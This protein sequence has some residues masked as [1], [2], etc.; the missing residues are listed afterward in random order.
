MEDEELP[1]SWMSTHAIKTD[2]RELLMRLHPEK[3]WPKRVSV[4]DLCEYTVH[5]IPADSQDKDSLR[6]L[7]MAHVLYDHERR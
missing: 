1:A 3:K 7:A 6:A 2:L 4:T 5:T